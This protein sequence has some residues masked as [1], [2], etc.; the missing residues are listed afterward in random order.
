MIHLFKIKAVNLIMI[1]SIIVFPSL[2]LRGQVDTVPLTKESRTC[3]SCHGNKYYSFHNSLTE[4]L[5]RK[6]MNPFL[7]IDTNNYSIGVHRN[8]SCTDCH[9][10]DYQKY[11]HQAELKL[12]P[13][14]SCIDCH[15]GEETYHFDQI[16]E[17]VDKSI[18]R[19][20]FG[21]QFKCEMCHNIHAY[22]P[23]ARNETSQ[24]RD[25]V[26]Q[27]NQMCLSCHNDLSKYQVL[28]EGSKA[29]ILKTH[30]W[31]PNQNSHFQNVRCIECHTPVKD[32][33]MVSH[34]ILPKEQ[35]VKLC[36]DCH[37]TNSILRDKLY[38]HKVRQSRSDKGFYNAT[39][40]NDS[41]V[42]GANRNKYFNVLSLIIFGLTLGGISLHLIF[43]I[44]KKK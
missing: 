25:I 18:H 21:S 40:L 15:G 2:D 38:K 26:L 31:L 22:Q 8:F 36:T 14:F 28:N 17:E 20:V 13:K 35:A 34:N 41:Y 4:E 11:P 24:I 44:I 1:A 32:T 3:A 42:I 12:E 29:E 23:I 43:R 27:N 16:N 7:I 39:F 33:M 19:T 6:R 37:S 9:S 10:Y 30:D 5:Q